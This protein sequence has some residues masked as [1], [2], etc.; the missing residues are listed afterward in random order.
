MT[1]E[2]QGGK[3]VNERRVYSR[4]ALL[5]RRP[6]DFCGAADVGA[7]AA[8]GAVSSCDRKSF[9]L[10]FWYAQNAPLTYFNA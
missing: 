6:I 1:A 8:N 9:L 10:W 3:E 5:R 4:L 7:G 2:S